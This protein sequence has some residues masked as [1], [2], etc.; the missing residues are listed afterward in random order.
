MCCVRRV[1]TAKVYSRTKQ[2]AERFAAEMAGRGD[3]PSL[4]DVVGSAADAASGADVICV[5]TTS[6]KPVLGTADVS[7]GQHINAVGSFSRAM[8]EL[9]PQLVARCRVIVDQREAA[10]EEAGELIAAIEAGL[11][12]EGDLVELG[13]VVA[14]KARGFSVD[15]RPSMFKSVG[16]AIQDMAAAAAALERAKSEEFGLEIQM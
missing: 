2:S 12:G 5:A 16:L 11:V 1:R 7:D 13:D 8:I 10:L 14:G 3:V 9:D 4:I 6:S 15:E